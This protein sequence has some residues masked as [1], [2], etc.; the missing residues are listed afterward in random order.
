MWCQINVTNINPCLPTPA[1]YSN[2]SLPNA[3]PAVY[4]ECIQP[5][6]LMIII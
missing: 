2:G 1:D 6:R 5:I 3:T 4:V